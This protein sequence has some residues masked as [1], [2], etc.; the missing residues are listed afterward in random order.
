MYS[1]TCLFVMALFIDR[2][3]MGYLPLGVPTIR[4]VCDLVVVVTPCDLWGPTL[5]LYR[6]RREF[7]IL[8]DANWI[9]MHLD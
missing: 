1:T 9:V 3:L 7:G 5:P 2:G 4:L 6:C 8:G